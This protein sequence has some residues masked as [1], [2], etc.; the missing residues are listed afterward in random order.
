MA[1]TTTLDFLTQLRANNSKDW[2]DQHRKQYDTAKADVITLMTDVLA[3]LERMD[4][5]IASSQLAVK[6]CLFR[7]NRDVRF[8]ANKSPYKSNFGGWFNPGGKKSASAGYYV[9]I[10]PGNS[11]VA[12]GMYMPEPAVL[13]TIRQEIDYNF[14]GFEEMLDALAFKKYYDGL[15]ME[16]ALVRPPK[17]YDADNPAIDYLKLKSFTASHKLTNKTVLSDDLSETV[18]AA[19]AG[20][21]PLVAFLNRALVTE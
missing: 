18:L 8:S 1:K 5:A 17:G 19:C 3:G 14:A 13:T 20:L 9:N 16:G 15:S 10:E 7:I 2:F 21:Q 4:P 6:S 12:G 11:F